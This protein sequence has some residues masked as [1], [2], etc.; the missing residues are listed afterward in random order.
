MKRLPLLLFL[1]AVSSS[2]ATFLI[3]NDR[4]LIAG[5]KAIVLATAG[6]SAGR[7]APGGWLETVTELRIDEAIKGPLA[8]G[9]TV[10]VVELGGVVGTRHYAVPGSPTYTPGERVL[11]F[12]D[13]NDRGEWVSKAMAIGKFS[14]RGDLLV[15]A[16]LCGANY[17]GTPHAEPLRARE[18]FL[19]FVR[20]VA[21]GRAAAEDYVVRG[22][23]AAAVVAEDVKASTY[24]IQWNGRQGTLGMRWKSFPSPVVFYS[25]GA[26]PGA[27]N[28]GLTAI[29]RGL[30]AW[31]ND[32]GSNI[33]YTYGGTTN[34]GSA[35]FTTNVS[36][37]TNVVL[38]ND[39]SNEI[40][41]SF[42]G[43]SGD[44]LAVGGGW[45]DDASPADT[46]TFG[47]ERFYTIYEADVVVQDGIF[48]AGLA[49]NGFDHVLTHELGHTLGLRH[50]DEPPPGGTTSFAAIMG[51]SVVFNSDP[52]GSTLQPWDIAAVGTLYGTSA[53]TCNAP[54]ITAQPQPA[55]LGASPATLGVTATGDAPLQ[56]RW[57]TGARGNTASPVSNGTTA[58]I[59]VQPSTTT[60]Y[61]VRVSNG[62]DPPADSATA[63]VT[64][65]GCPAVTVDTITPGADIV[66]GA[67][68]TLNATATGA[69]SFQW[70]AGN[71]GNTLAPLVGKTTASIDVTPSVT[72]TYWVRASN[73]C[74]AFADSEPVL[75][76]VT[77][78]QRPGIAVQPAPTNVLAG[79]GATLYVGASGS[80]P[81]TIVWYEGSRSDASH[82]VPNGNAAL[83]ITPPLFAPTSYWAR[84]SN[85]CGSADSNVA[86]VDIVPAC[87]APLITEEPRAAAVPM[88]TSARLSVGATGTSLTY[89]W[90]E[91]PVLDFT[92]PLGGSAPLLVTPPITAATQFW[93]RVSSPCGSANSTA[94]A[95]SVAAAKRRAAGR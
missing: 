7:R 23:S 74:G 19:Q 78:C 45:F 95:V 72:T 55:T 4:D 57:Y 18:A 89:Q 6:D 46:H 8:A 67:T 90:Y 49:A 65:N 1:I 26:Q 75:V 27:T 84:V 43:K 73:N 59:N 22:A 34:I 63:T 17:D 3:P 85:L 11:L 5:A 83:L 88:G 92:R 81:M 60:V 56:Y 32:T 33:V 42:T 76:T 10:R 54:Q 15:R 21:H 24:C 79:N 48:G 70:Y 91:G 16:P 50:S 94:A 58:S 13:T 82:P 61:W 31:T 12:L 14:V 44:V 69:T 39:P 53:G 68:A 87:S 35:G 25:H 41:G 77:P 36:D 40:A 47:G 62:C 51:S 9:E 20:D 2:A 38:F 37:G 52:Y 93:V 64:V 28:G 30:A 80:A 66:E 71:S 29:Q 86:N